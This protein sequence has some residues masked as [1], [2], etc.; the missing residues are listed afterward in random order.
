[1]KK[2]FALML[3]LCLM[4]CS[5][6]LAEGAV[7]MN[8]ADVAP[9][10]EE[11]GGQFLAIELGLAV[12]APNDFYVVNEIPEAYA[13]KGIYGMFAELDNEGN[14]TGAI[15]LQYVKANGATVEE[16]V[17][18]IEGAADPK[19][20]VINGYPCVN[21]DL[22]EMDATCVAFGTE[23]GNLFV[24]SFLPISNPDFATKA[25]IMV[26]SLQSAE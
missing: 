15:T 23:Q 11:I 10:A 26:A 2:L 19:S 18:N 7:E 1:M 24:I 21:F 14:M 5:A 13:E 6:A 25:T 16:C 8:W 4:L 9:A 3:T 20:M 12:W 17:S 22:P